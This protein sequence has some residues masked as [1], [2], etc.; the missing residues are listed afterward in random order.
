MKKLRWSLS[1]LLTILVCCGAAA[2]LENDTVKVGLR[3]GSSAMFSANLENA[4]GS[5]YAFGYYDGSRSFVEVGETGKTTVSVTAAGTI[6]LGSSGYY[7]SDQGQGVIGSWRAETAETYASFEEAAAAAESYPGSYVAYISDTYRLRLGCYETESEAVLALANAGLDGS[8]VAA[9]RTGVVV[10]V[11]KTATV[12]FEFD[13]QGSRSFAILPDGQ[14]QIAETW[15][16]FYKYRGGFE[17]PRVTGGKL[18][19][20]NVVDRE[21]YVKGVIP[22]EMSGSWPVEALAAQAVC[23]RTYVSRATKHSAAYGFDVC[24]TTDCQVY[25][26]RGNS[27]S[28]PSARSDAAVDETAGLCLYYGVKLIEA[29]YFSSDGG[30]TE[31]AK[32]VWGGDLA[33]LKGKEDPY[34]ALVTIPGYRYTTT[35]TKDELTWVLQ[36]SGYSIGTV[37]KVYVSDYTAMGNVYKVTFVDSGGNTLTVQG[38]KCRTIFYSST[39][40]KSVRSLR[41]TINGQSQGAELYINDSATKIASTQ[42]AY[43]ISGKGTVT[44]LDGN[45]WVLTSCG[46]SQSGGGV[47][48]G[49]GNDV[50]I[51]GTGSGHHVG[52]SQW[53]AKAMAEQGYGYE[54]ILHFYYTDVDLY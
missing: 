47:P 8:A 17:Y 18:S 11:T 41:F 50:T 7:E 1:F 21:D 54:E 9:S 19:V 39:L 35:Y 27:T 31:D 20:I 23:A 49:S 24:N 16:R 28:G 33:Y 14:G 40:G 34:E 42:G 36:N 52:M 13:C 44:A 4:V 53:G 48:S 22:Y 15:F 26:G 51:T 5:G 32:N 25:Y 43:A 38:D 45:A 3:Y 2:A 46:M 37:E 10:T 12:L 6:Y 30:A 29:V